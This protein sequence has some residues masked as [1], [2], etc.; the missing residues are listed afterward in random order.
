MTTAIAPGVDEAEHEDKGA[1]R[2]VATVDH[3]RIGILYLLTALVFFLIGGLEAL[4]I[5]LQLARPLSNLLSPDTF[6]QLFTMHGTT[7]IFLVVMPTLV[8]FGNYF[9]P[10]M[11]G[12]RDMAFPRLNAMSYWLFPF[13]G[14]L[15]HFSLLAGGAPAAGWFS[16]A[17]LSETPFNSTT[18]TDYWALALF[19]LGISSVAGGINIIATVITLR[20]P[21]LT[22]RRLPLFVWMTFITAILIILALPVLNAA[23]VMLLIDRQLDAHFFQANG[24]GSAILWQHFFWAFG[25]PEVYIMA[26]PAFG[27]I[28]E[29]IPVFSRNR[30]FGYEFIAASTVAIAVLSFGVWAHHMFA[31]GLGHRVDLAFAA[32][33]MLIAVP[34]GVKI[35]NW[36][37]TMWGGTIRL[38]TAMAFAV[39]FLVEFVIGGLSGVQFAAAPVDWQLT[40]SYYVVAHFHY[41][42]FGG[43]VFAVFAATYYWFPK[44]TGRLLSE[45]WGKVHFWMTVLGF[46]LTFFVQHFLGVL[47]MP[48]RV[49]TYPDLP[50]WGTINM[51]STIGAF[52]LG[53]SVMVFL[54]NGGYSL[55]RGKIAGDNPWEAWTLEWAT[56]SPPPPHNFDR[57]P[58]VR[59]RRPLWDL[60]Q[61]AQEKQ[62]TQEKGEG[63]SSGEVTVLAPHDKAVIG[64]WTFIVS[65]TGF[66]IILII[67]YVFFNT[68]TKAAAAHLDVTTTAAFSACLFASS[69]TIRMSEKGLASGRR[70]AF[71]GWLFA[72][73]VLG[74]VFMAGQ[75][76][77]YQK[78]FASGLSV[79]SS[80]FASTFFTLTGFHGLHVTLGL[81]ALGVLFGLAL[82]GDFTGR[83]SS[84]FKAVG[85]YWHFVDAVWVAVFSIVYLRNLL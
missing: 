40:D 25:H 39:A 28:S 18:G 31:A 17:P 32:S 68:S 24:G 52:V 67:T 47:G 37:A 1:F 65:E 36:I 35:L 69:F 19:V 84:A 29:V 23:L 60:A 51:L 9:V 77:E 79:D 2:W 12:A 38:T 10:L 7:M 11:I 54:A 56:T 59:G 21:G 63:E 64:V 74:A 27:M 78:L 30:I 20:A 66:F 50:W 82:A 16:Y 76:R 42:L 49:F 14:A 46:N 8:G 43:T 55:V 5:R 85:L 73:L 3:K 71:R 48:R 22:I 58:P 41:V 34:T 45:R 70:G 57:V 72:T 53:V 62:G 83:Q 15:L 33:S 4:A 81:L 75:G 26:L 80:L 61:E 6:N 13:G 44:M